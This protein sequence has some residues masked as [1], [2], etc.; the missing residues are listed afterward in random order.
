M[1]LP[2]SCLKQS[3]WHWG[4]AMLRQL[5]PAAAGTMQHLCLLSGLLAPLLHAARPGCPSA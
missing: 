4:E 2:I 1:V 5:T 3:C